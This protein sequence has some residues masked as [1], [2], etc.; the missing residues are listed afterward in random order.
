MLKFFL[1]N[2]SIINAVTNFEM[3]VI[4]LLTQLVLL[5]IAHIHTENFYTLRLT[6]TTHLRS[7]KRSI[8]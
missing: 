7:K 4:K 6:S 8:D 1:L 3:I 5:Q 2:E